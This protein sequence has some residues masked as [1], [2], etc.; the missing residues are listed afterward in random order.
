VRKPARHDVEGVM[1][2][3]S[4]IALIA[5]VVIRILGR[6]PRMAG[7]VW[8]EQAAR[9]L[10]VWMA[11]IA[12]AEVGRQNVHL[13]MGFPAERIPRLI[14]K[15]VFTPTDLVHPGVMGHL[16]GIGRTTARRARN[17]A[18]VSPPFPEALPCAS[19]ALAAVLVAHRI[20]PRLLSGQSAAAV[21]GTTP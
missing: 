14:R 13:R 7:P 10:W 5:V 11:F 19:A 3:L 1:A 2:A 20:A 8:T 16:A 6:T 15:I 9:W 17:H 4:F 21:G 18:A 12:I